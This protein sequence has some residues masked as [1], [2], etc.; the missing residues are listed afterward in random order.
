MRNNTQYLE[1][2]N[3]NIVFD[4]NIYKII[5]VSSIYIYG[6]QYVHDKKN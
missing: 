4:N 5:K 6:L 2:F 1:L 3:K